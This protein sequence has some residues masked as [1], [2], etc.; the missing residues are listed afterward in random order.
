MSNQD[1]FFTPE[2]VDRQIDQVFRY[3]EGERADAEA[4]AYLRSFYGI[5]TQQEQG[6]LNR[7]WNRIADA[8]PP[9]QH[10]PQQNQE[11]EKVLAM[12]YQPAL[13]G[14]LAQHKRHTRLWQRLGLLAAAVFMVALVGSMALLFNSIRHN[15]GGPASGGTKPPVVVTT[16]PPTPT[17]TMT[18]TSVPFKVT[19]VDMSVVPGSIAGVACGTYVTVTYKATIHVLPHGPGGTIHFG[20]TVNNG[21]SQNMASVK[22]ASQ[23]TSVT[24]TFTW[25]GALPADHTYPGPGGINVTSPN[26]L[27]SPMVGPS[28]TCK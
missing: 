15:P 8:V 21:R 7:I 28:G 13:S 16:V 22:I 12:Q 25:S 23:Q 27:I 3:T 14:N 11:R 4:M 1:D 2:E 5:N 24:Y 6:M 20:Y 26:Q 19:S 10:D 9:I 17:P 18:T